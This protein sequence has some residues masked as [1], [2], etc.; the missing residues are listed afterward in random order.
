MSS[1]DAS[2]FLGAGCSAPSL[3]GETPVLEIRFSPPCRAFGPS[4]FYIQSIV[5]E[6]IRVS[7]PGLGV[8]QSTDPIHLC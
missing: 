8:P 1:D 6:V 5:V 3:T 2:R 7:T 4:H